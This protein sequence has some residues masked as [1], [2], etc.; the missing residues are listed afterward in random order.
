M[1]LEFFRT[2]HAP[3]CAAYND[4]AYGRETLAPLAVLAAKCGFEDIEIPNPN[5]GNEL[6]AEWQRIRELKPDCVFLRGWGI[7]TPVAIKTAARIGFPA[8]RIIGDVWSGSEDDVIPAGAAAKGFLA[9]TTNAAG[10]D[11]PFLQ[12]LKKYILDKGKS[13]LKD[14]SRFGTAYY[15]AGVIHALVTIEALHTAYAKFGAH[16]IN[17]EQGRTSPSGRIR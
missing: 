12:E 15:N 9:A 13:D 17:G 8:D 4:S 10:T 2:R 3:A 14:P 1:T 6:S 7:Q 5:P 11:F 16:P